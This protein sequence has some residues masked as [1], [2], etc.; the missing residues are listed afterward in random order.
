MVA[1][2]RCIRPLKLTGRLQVKRPGHSAVLKKALLLS[3]L[4]LFAGA[5]AEVE[6]AYPSRSITMIVPFAAGEPLDEVARIIADAMTM[7]LGKPIVIENASGAG[8]ALSVARVARAPADGYT[9]LMYPIVTAST[10]A[11]YR[12]RLPS[13]P[14]RNLAPV[15]LV[16]ELPMVLVGRRS[17]PSL[18]LSDFIALVRSNENRTMFA[19]AG[20]GSASYLCGLLLMA[21]LN[22]SVTTIRYRGARPAMNSLIAGHVDAICDLVTNARRQIR[23]G[24][25]RAYAVTGEKR[26]WALAGIPTAREAG[27][28]N[29]S[30]TS[31]NAIFAPKGIP[32]TAV[33]QL[34]EALRTTL[35]E[36]TVIKRLSELGAQPV[37]QSR[38]G[39]ERLRLH[40]ALEISRWTPRI[41]QSRQLPGIEPPQII[42]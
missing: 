15:S 30:I 10:A 23:D 26:T 21:E 12:G 20:V 3:F 7:P 38:A 31:W 33:Q 11:L 17:S 25:I 24:K 19:H 28:P 18:S 5:P 22:V 6:T 1:G 9:I 39:P 13:A 40:I 37:E 36:P 32:D 34:Q 2:P 4:A 14:V 8:G 42:E 29:L 35:R 27:L 41:E 16:N